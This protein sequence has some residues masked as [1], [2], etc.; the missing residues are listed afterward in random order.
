M[1]YFANSNDCVKLSYSRVGQ[2]HGN[3]LRNY[4]ISTLDVQKDLL[5][6]FGFDILLRHGMGLCNMLPN[7]PITP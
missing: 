5:G 1:M 6:I 7:S 2:Y 3:I 4:V